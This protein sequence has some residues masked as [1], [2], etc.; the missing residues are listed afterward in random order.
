MLVALGEMGSKELA[1]EARREYVLVKWQAILF[2]LFE[3][4]LEVPEQKG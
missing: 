3:S 2:C 1:L 4:E